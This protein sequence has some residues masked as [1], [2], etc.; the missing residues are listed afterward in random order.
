MLAR[1]LVL[2]PHEKSGFRAARGQRIERRLMRTL[3]KKL[4]Q[5]FF[6]RPP[7]VHGFAVDDLRHIRSLIVQV[8]DQ[9]RLRGTNDYASR[10][11]PNI[12]AMRAEVT[13][14]RGMIFGVDEDRVVRTSSHARLA[15]DADRFIEIDDAVGTLE[16]SGG[17]TGDD[18][19]RVCALIA[20][21]DLMG[22][23]NLWEDTDVDMF[24]VSAGNTDRHNIFRFAGS[25]A[26]VA[27]D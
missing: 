8:A 11:Q 5:S 6:L 18:A 22:A 14:F 10:L 15:A 23:A 13:F 2:A 26:R 20:A 21:R 16:H 4:W 12:D 9:D 25:R 19:R 1:L 24:D 17:R 27:A 3:I 7:H